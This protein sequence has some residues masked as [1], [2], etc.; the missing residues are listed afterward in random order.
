MREM[1]ERGRVPGGR[2]CIGRGLTTLNVLLIVT[3][4]SVRDKS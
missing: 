1:D 4:N 2:R 3:H